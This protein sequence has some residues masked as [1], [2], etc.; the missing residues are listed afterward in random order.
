MKS[1]LKAP[2]KKNKKKKEKKRTNARKKERKLADHRASC[3]KTV[4]STNEK[5][6][7]RMIREKI[8]EMLTLRYLDALPI[9]YFFCLFK[10]SWLYN[11][12]LYF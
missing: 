4:Q 8:F 1:P 12:A 2:P 10:G 9:C 11:V 6:S 3:S 5:V 7:L